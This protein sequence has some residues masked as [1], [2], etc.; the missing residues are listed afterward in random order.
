MNNHTT[1]IKP[2]LTV[3]DAIKAVE[4]YKSAFGAIEVKR[5]EMQNQKISSVVVIENAEFYLSDE[6]PENGNLSPDLKTNSAI[7]I[8]L[9]TKNADKIFEK[10]LEF[11]AT[12]ICAIKTEE[13][14][15]IGKLKDP[16]GHIWEIGYTL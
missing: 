9:E 6:E 15:R 14:W 4:F 12:E 3:N 8:I 10:A 2:F 5:F 11:G 16:Y 7:R 1:T 13:D